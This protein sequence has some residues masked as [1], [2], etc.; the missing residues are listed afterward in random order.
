MTSSTDQTESMRGVRAGGVVLIGILALNA[1][2]YV[3]HLLAAR[4]LG[5]A[6]YGEVVS[7]LA[8]AGLIA[9]PLGGVQVV[10]ART[11]SRLASVNNVD[12]LRA[13]IRTGLI[14]VAGA[15]SALAVVLVMLAPV[16]RGPLG[17]ESLAAI[18]L[19]A[20]LT[21]PALVAPIAL[22]V[23]QGLQR[24]TLFSFTLAL[25]TVAR[26]AALV[27]VLGLGLRVAGVM[28]A[29]IVGSVVALAVPVVGIREHLRGRRT[30]RWPLSGAAL[31]SSVM[32]SVV[33]LLAI[34][35]LTTADVIVAK[36]VLSDHDAGVYGGASLIGR[37]I[38]HLPAVILTVLLPKVSAR[39]ARGETTADILAASIRV[40][41]AAAAV[42]TLI[43]SIAPSL[44]VR[45]AF[46]SEYDDAAGLLPL[47]GIAMTGYAVL[48]V[49][50][51]YHL[52]RSVNSMSW[53]LLA[54]ACVQLA[55]YGLFHDSAR[56]LLAV[57]IGSMVILLI[58]HE[59]LVQRTLT[60]AVIRMGG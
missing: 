26:L 8:L 35:A 32:P 40:V 31:R 38:F 10:V 20:V 29:T 51:I 48:N 34:T 9:L 47:F 17:V 36:A 46:G 28:A 25:S 60:S 5:P 41:V 7:L 33:G 58:T 45:V 13:Y 24:F 14:V 6:S 52:A 57:S 42:L 30:E 49:L 39:T 50:L 3:F 16:I 56:Q 22:G 15:S 21:V 19:T 53:L 18:V 27:A 2:N 55:G 54:G 1:G 12:A 11:V 23:A 37:V 43:Y 4:E 59:L 44:V